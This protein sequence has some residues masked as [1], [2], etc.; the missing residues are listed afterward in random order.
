MQEFKITTA[1]HSGCHVSVIEE[2]GNI[3]VK[4]SSND[5]SYIPRLKKQISK[6][7]NFSLHTDMICIPEIYGEF[8]YK[9][10]YY[11]IMEYAMGVDF[12][13]F[14][15]IA[16]PDDVD[17][18]CHNL[19]DFISYEMSRSVY[20][21]FPKKAFLSKIS[22]IKTH[23]N[24]NQTCID[25]CQKIETL[26]EKNHFPNI[27]FG[28]CHGDLTFS[29]IMISLK[30]GRI[31]LID[32]L[33]TFVESPLQ[34]IVKIQQ[35]TLYKWIFIKN[36]FSKDRMRSEMILKKIDHMLNLFIEENK[37]D[38]NTLRI[39]QI[40]NLLRIIPYTHC[41]KIKNFLLEKITLEVTKISLNQNKLES[42]I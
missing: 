29:N 6:Q 18:L 21:P 35:D 28:E 41:E 31:F 19:F 5:L 25:I 7:K 37:I 11:C 33:D 36:N 42:I 8:H 23:P 13:E 20:Q 17:F 39:F 3:L 24:S 12:I 1:G 22:D 38:K 10:V 9:N 40:V 4:K 26:I 27:P 32:F 30:N 14:S 2:S 16:S 15:R 34:D